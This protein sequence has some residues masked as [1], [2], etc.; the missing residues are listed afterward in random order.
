MKVYNRLIAIL[1]IALFVGNMLSAF[2]MAFATVAG[3]VELTLPTIT[4]AGGPVQIDAIDLT[5]TGGTIYFYLSLDNDPVISSGDIRF[6]NLKAAD[7]IGE[8]VTVWLPASVA[9]NDEYYVKVV[10]LAQTGRDCV[11]ADGTLEVVAE[12]YPTVTIDESTGIVGDTPE[13]AVED[14]DDYADVTVDWKEYDSDYQ[15]VYAGA[16]VDGEYTVEDYAI[17]HDFKGTYKIVV[18]LTDADGDT[19]GSWVEFTIEPDVDW[20]LVLAPNISILANELDQTFTITGTGFSAGT[21]AEDSIQFVLKNFM[22]GSTI[23]TYETRHDEVDVDEYDEVDAP[24]ELNGDLTILVTVDAVEPGVIDVKIPVDST[25]ETFAAAFYSSEPTELAD[26][27]SITNYKMSETEGQ[28]GDD[29]N[30]S[31]INLPAA[32]A[33]TIRWTG[34]TITEDVLVGTADAN[35]AFDMDYEI[36]QLPGGAYGVRAMTTRERSLGNFEVLSKF[37]VRDPAD[38][39]EVLDEAAVEDLVNLYGSGFPADAVIQTY[40][41]GDEDT[42]FDPEINVA[43]TGEFEVFD[44]E[45]PHVSGGGLAV[46]VK[47]DGENADGD[48]FSE[49]SSIII[50]PVLIGVDTGDY[51]VGTLAW[52]GAEW[53][54]MPYLDVPLYPGHIVKVAGYGFK[55]GEE[56]GLKVYDDDGDLVGSAVIG[57]GAK[58]QTDGDVEMV[59]WLPNAKVLYP[60]GMPG[61]SWEVA[62][63][64]ATNAYETDP[65]IDPIDFD[66]SDNAAALLILGLANDGDVDVDVN[67][68]E[69][70][71]AVGLGFRDKTLTLNIVEP[72]DDVKTVSQVNGYFDT[73]FTVPELEG[74]IDGEDYTIEILDIQ[75]IFW[76]NPNIVL[77]PNKAF[78]DGKFVV[79]GTGFEGRS[80]ID[81]TWMGVVEDDVLDT[82]DGDDIED[83]SF[84]MELT[85][86]NVVPMQYKLVAYTE[87]MD[88]EWD[89]AAFTVLDE[90]AAQQNKTLNDILAQ[91][92]LLD[93][94][95]LNTNIQA[96]STAVTAASTAATAAGTKADAAAA[97]ATAAGTKADAA[98]AAATAAGTKADAAKTAADAAK[99]AADSAASAANGLTTLVYAAI[100]ASLIAA[101]AAIVALMQIS[102]KIA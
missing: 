88:E 48:A 21:V 17:P 1:T 36:F 77:T 46:T 87:D 8:V 97:A 69:T 95:T 86:P 58:A 55:A 31:F 6:G 82:V 85:V 62:G 28:N 102:R 27:T 37:E 25:T 94:A 9:V 32:E 14:A 99:T 60:A 89:N 92:K 5:A 75:D 79:T 52:N 54:F 63:S 38:P 42:D 56:V 33:V 40:W 74:A 59:A 34:A 64:T 43:D 3:D 66:A 16:I 22:T 41:F 49:A 24:G 72:D 44:V 68:G 61:C 47:V 101:L 20:D 2:P 18:W 19:F 84:S 96:A 80:G 26:F 76:L 10:D 30:F 13:I 15:V 73:S 53:E 98:T 4:I 78:V 70:L 57:D 12:D 11:V 23:E 45:I 93:I 100:G 71:R 29:V 50:N 83:G 7:V 90:A 67:V 65:D 35:G 81:L 91:L 51:D 39:T